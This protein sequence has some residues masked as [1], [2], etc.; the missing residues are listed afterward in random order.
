MEDTLEF[1]SHMNNLGSELVNEFNWGIQNIT[2]VFRC[3]TNEEIKGSKSYID[4]NLDLEYVA[5][6]DQ[7][8][9][10]AVRYGAVVLTA[11]AG[12][13]IEYSNGTKF[14]INADRSVGINSADVKS[15]VLATM[16]KVMFHNERTKT[17]DNGKVEYFFDEQGTDVAGSIFNK[18]FMV[19]SLSLIHI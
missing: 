3:L 9:R 10:V 14:V 19:K 7:P 17:D 11:K 18:I 4:K 2:N 12:T 8:V 13:V 16:A 5:P 6:I 15:G 1:Y